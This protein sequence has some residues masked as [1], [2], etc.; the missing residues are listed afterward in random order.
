MH[1][2]FQRA[3]L[4]KRLWFLILL[5]AALVLTA[6]AAWKPSFAQWYAIRIY[7]ALSLT[8]N[9]ITGLVPFSVAE[10]LVIL[11]LLCIPVILIFFAAGMIRKKGS[12]P[13]FALK[14]AVNLAVFFSIVSFL[15]TINCGIN[16][17][18][19]PFADTCGLKVEP[20][21]STELNE[22]CVSLASDAN[23]LRPGLKADDQG[24]MELRQKSLSM[25]A[26]EA[27][28][29][30]NRLERDYPLLRSGY[31]APKLVH[32]SRAMS[33]CN[34]TGIFFPFT[35]EANVNTDVPEY[36]IPVTMCHE[37]S[38]LR[39]Y[40]REEEANFIGYLVCSKSGE[41]DFQYSGDM[42]AFTYASNALF[43]VDA[44]AADKIFS[45]LSSGVR[46][47]LAYNSEYWK[48]FEGP[49]AKVSNSVNDQYLKANSQSDGVQ[50]YG[51]MVDLLL[52]QQRAAKQKS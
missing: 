9:R 34:I 3:G 25:T 18:R 7:P 31:G 38:H 21:T 2:I 17:Y 20:S 41:P 37:L 28:L 40:M 51:R 39:G 8:V 26:Q 13:L 44:D 33:R 11:L 6:C 29:A 16:Y 42:L 10:C 14:S 27:A 30:Y 15:F 46:R 43:S 19:Y 24:V 32:F 22:L 45:S 4:R 1:R 52:A 5:P 48:Q 49:V 47:D 35:L 50:S 12:R 36:T 23:R